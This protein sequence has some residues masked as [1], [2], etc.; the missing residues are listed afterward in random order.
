[1]CKSKETGWDN[2]IATLIRGSE[3][4]QNLL[5]AQ[6]YRFAQ[7][8]VNSYS[9]AMTHP[10]TCSS[11]KEVKGLSLLS[12]SHLPTETQHHSSPGTCPTFL[13]SDG[14]STLISSN[15]M[16]FPPWCQ[17]LQIHPCLC[18][19]GLCQYKLEKSYCSL[20]AYHTSGQANDYHAL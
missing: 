13:Q 10:H 8:D 3:M 11:V 9:M 18:S 7:S 4:S 19:Q 6:V 12:L 2:T 1:M 5:H 20:G 15:A 17:T 16:F 14:W